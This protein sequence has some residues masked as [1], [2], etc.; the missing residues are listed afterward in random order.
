[1]GLW[2][3]RLVGGL[4][5]LIPLIAKACK[6]P[7][8]WHALHWNFLAGHWNPSKWAESPHLGHLS[9]YLFASLGSKFLLKWHWCWMF[10][11]LVMW[12]P[13]LDPLFSSCILA[14]W[15]FSLLVVHE[16]NLGGLQVTCYL[17]DV[18]CSGLWTL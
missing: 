13:L 17:P 14:W 2:F 5:L 3:P 11:I 18:P 9:L 12:L 10:C 6:W 15:E 16:I 4:F 7:N 8:V 1:M